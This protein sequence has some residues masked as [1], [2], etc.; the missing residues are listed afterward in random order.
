MLTE[1]TTCSRVG[2]E[3]S[4][5]QGEAR[6]DEPASR[7]VTELDSASLRYLG[8]AKLPELPKPAIIGEETFTSSQWI[9]RG[10]WRQRVGKEK[11]RN[12]RDPV[13][14]GYVRESDT[15]IVARKRGNACGAKGGDCKYATVE[16]KDAPA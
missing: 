1:C 12:L 9:P 4:N 5:P 7:N 13:I 10:G 11:S 16:V 15:L 2:T 8:M 3:R 6:Q 14:S